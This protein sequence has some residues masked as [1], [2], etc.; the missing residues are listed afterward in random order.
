MSRLITGISGAL[1]LVLIGGAAQF[2]MGRD[3]SSVAGRLSPLKPS[4]ST[5]LDMNEVN[6]G[7]KADRAA[8][9]VGSP[10]LLRT[11]SVKLNGVADT[12]VLMRVPVAV[13][14][15]PPPTSA[16]PIFRKPMLACEAVVSVLTEIAGK[17]A[18][19]RCVT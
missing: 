17:L 10:A 12:I 8:A 16:K 2:A 13:A 6:R 4:S 11:V 14:A 7:A 5:A 18:P 9:P 3:L 1:A 19:G 15:P